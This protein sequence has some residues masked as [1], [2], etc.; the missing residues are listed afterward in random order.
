VQRTLILHEGEAGSETERIDDW[1]EGMGQAQAKMLRG[2]REI[3]QDYLVS[4][5]VVVIASPLDLG[6]GKSQFRKGRKHHG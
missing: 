2:V 3:I 5:V 6:D 1:K 4:H